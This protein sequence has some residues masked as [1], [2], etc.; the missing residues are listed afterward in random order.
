MKNIK[1]TIAIFSLATLFTACD[2]EQKEETTQPVKTEKAE[3]KKESHTGGG[4][5]L[6]L[7]NGD[8]WI[9]NKETTHGVNSIIDLMDSF[10]DKDDVSAYQE[11]AKGVKAK[12]LMIFNKCTMTGESH[13][14]LHTF[15]YPIKDSLSDLSS[16]DIET[17]KTSFDK[18]RTHLDEYDKFFVTAL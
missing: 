4:D 6:S 13:N 8:K 1:F 15:L 12:F 9:A 7:N 2:S 5:H 11:L 14:Q 3:P 17:C 16:G 18:L 10:S